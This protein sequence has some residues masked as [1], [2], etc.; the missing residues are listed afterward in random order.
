[1]KWIWP[2]IWADERGG[3]WRFVVT[4]TLFAGSV[5]LGIVLFTAAMLGGLKNAI[6]NEPAHIQEV[7][8]LI[9]TVL[10][11]GLGL[12]G[13]LIGIRFVHHKPIRCIF[14]DGRPFRLGFAVQSA[15]L[16]ALLWFAG[17]IILPNGWELL[18]RRAG[19]I[20]L[21]WWPVLSVAMFCAMAVGRTAEEIMFRGY[22]LTRVAAWVKRPWLAVC[23][24]A[25]VFALVHRG[26]AAAY[27]AIALFGIASGAACIRA[28]TLAPMIGLHTAHDTLESLWHP[29]ETNAGATWLDVA[30][31]A[32][33]L[34]IWFGWLLWATRT[35]PTYTLERQD[36]ELKHEHTHAG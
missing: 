8:Q 14:T 31:I 12:A 3:W 34:S 18:V 21:A 23:I 32:V 2:R 19:E 10:I 6:N 20:P 35:R 24:S 9:G 17:T 28:G 7:I 4:I 30:F 1:M 29:K 16:W 13:L 5:V 27:T 36:I 26:N 22:L 25:L 15:A 11:T 33:A